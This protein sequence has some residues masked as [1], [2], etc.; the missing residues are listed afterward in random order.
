VRFGDRLFEQIKGFGEYGFPESHMPRV[1]RFLV[2][3]SSWL[4]T[5]HPAIFACALHQL[6]ADG[7]LLRLRKSSP[8]PSATGS[9]CF[10]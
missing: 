1:L 5:Y 6:V 2:Y 7:F 3:A 4:K 9:L 8:T 10:R